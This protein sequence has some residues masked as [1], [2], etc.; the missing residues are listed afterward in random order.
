MLGTSRFNGYAYNS[1]PYEH[2][3]IEALPQDPTSIR[4]PHLWADNNTLRGHHREFETQIRLRFIH[5]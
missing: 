5:L 3:W 2:F 1:S 4:Q